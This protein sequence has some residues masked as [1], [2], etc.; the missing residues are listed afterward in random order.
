MGVGAKRAIGLYR[1]CAPRHRCN[2]DVAVGL[3][4]A[5]QNRPW[6]GLPGTLMSGELEELR[7]LRKEVR[8]FRMERDFLK[9]R[10]RASRA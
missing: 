4:E 10:Q 2:G 5:G 6:R 1:S 3:G 7:S 8:D 9:E